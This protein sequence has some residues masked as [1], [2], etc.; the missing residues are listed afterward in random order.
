MEFLIQKFGIDEIKDLVKD[1][2][3]KKGWT[4]HVKLAVEKIRSYEEKKS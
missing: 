1:Y 3:G 2:E 4:E